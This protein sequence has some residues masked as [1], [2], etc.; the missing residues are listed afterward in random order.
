MKINICARKRE[1]ASGRQIPAPIG[2]TMTEKIQTLAKQIFRE[3]DCKGVVRIDFLV[4]NRT[5][6]LY[7]NE[8]NTI[9]GSMAFYAGSRA[10]CPIRL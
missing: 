2:E 10:A 1:N 4:D 3:M 7:V 9:P 5:N 8:I 6:E